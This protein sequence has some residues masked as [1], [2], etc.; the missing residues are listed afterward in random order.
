[1]LSRSEV[2]TAVR[3]AAQRCTLE[4]LCEEAVTLLKENFPPYD[5]V[6]IYYV[7][8]RNLNLGPY[9]GAPTE[10][11]IIPIGEGICGAA[12][13][14]DAT[15]VVPDVTADSRYIACSIETRSEI[16]VPVKRDGEA[17][18]EIDIDSHTPDAFGDEDRKMIEE[19]ADILAERF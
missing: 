16:V 13:A 9:L 2:V 17:F 3:E 15:I 10:H 12:V 14:E 4:A 11:Q 7:C 1:M 6:G 5:W 19:I 8:G 18:A